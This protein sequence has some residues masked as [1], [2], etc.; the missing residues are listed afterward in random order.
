MP[1]MDYKDVKFEDRPSDFLKLKP[2]EN[3]IRIGSTQ[4]FVHTRHSV[5]EDDKWTVKPHTVPAEKCE[6][7]QIN[8]KDGKQAY[9][10]QQ[11]YSWLIFDRADKNAVR[12]LDVGFSVFKQ[13]HAFSKDAEYGAPTSYDL[14]INKTGEGKDTEYAV[15]PVPKKV[16]LTADEEDAL[17]ASN[18]DLDKIFGGG[19]PSKPLGPGDDDEEEEVKV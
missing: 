9:P 19:T 18:I 8:G 6:V 2:G 11:R 7:C 4:V 14:K 12:V 5:K 16:P 15:I 10:P 17:L 1:Y 13:I 3:R